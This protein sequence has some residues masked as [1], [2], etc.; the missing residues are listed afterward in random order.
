M[1]YDSIISIINNYANI[2]EENLVEGKSYET[3][4]RKYFQAVLDICSEKFLTVYKNN[5]TSIQSFYKYYEYIIGKDKNKIN[6]NISSDFNKKEEYN[7]LEFDLMVDHVN[8]K[9]IKKIIN[10]FKSSIIAINF[11]ENA[12]ESMEYQIIGEVAKS[13]LNQSIDKYKQILKI[14]DIMLIE[15]YFNSRDVVDQEN[16][17]MNYVMKDYINLKL[18]LNQNKFIFLFT[19]GSFLELKKA[20]LFKKEELEKLKVDYNT[21]KIKSVFPIININRYFKNILYLNK[22]IESLNKSKIPYIIFYIGEELNNGIEKILI[23]H[24]KKSKKKNEYKKIIQKIEDNEKLISK[25]ISQSFLIRSIYKSLK[26]LNKKEIF[27]IIKNISTIPQE[28]CYDYFEFLYQNLIESKKMDN[29][30]DILLFFVA[31]NKFPNFAQKKIDKFNQENL[32]TNMKLIY[33]NEKDLLNIESKY[34]D[35][36]ILKKIIILEENE[37]KNEIIFKYDIKFDVMDIKNFYRFN[38]D[39]INAD[40]IEEIIKKYIL[41]HFAHFSE[42]KYMNF[43][44]LHKKII[45]DIKNMEDILPIKLKEYNDDKMFIEK[46]KELKNIILTNDIIEKKS[47]EI[48]LKIKECIG[49]ELYQYFIEKRENEIKDIIKKNLIKVSEHICCFILYEKFFMNYVS[50]IVK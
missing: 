37:K 27:D 10:I 46:I 7:K 31:N 11:D 1:N 47:D 16:D 26:L 38:F 6:D 44:L 42:E 30:Y 20:V 29:P 5:G 4:V 45:Y 3:K 35:K 39:S 15:Q 21:S 19:D 50:M 43:D 25:N 22:I 23:N 41:S 32:L 48:L 40:K 36:K 2:E 9:I 14:R 13:I 8:I 12:S 33:A 34:N 49:I 28:I 24:I 18:D 17:I